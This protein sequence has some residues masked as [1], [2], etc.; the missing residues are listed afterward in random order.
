M[1]KSLTPVL[2]NS[3]SSAFVISAMQP[4]RW[5]IFSPFSLSIENS[6]SSG[7]WLDKLDDEN[8]ALATVA[9]CSGSYEAL[10]I[11]CAKQN[12]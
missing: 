3:S 4:S 12:R 1:L 8:E 10:K 11:L 9:F 7:S 6:S 5:G 2:I